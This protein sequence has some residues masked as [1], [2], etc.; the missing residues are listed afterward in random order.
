MNWIVTTEWGNPVIRQAVLGFEQG[1]RTKKEAKEDYI[2][3]Q[4]SGANSHMVCIQAYLD[5]I[6]KAKLL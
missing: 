2:K 5:R 6:Q 3:T 4:V 1:F